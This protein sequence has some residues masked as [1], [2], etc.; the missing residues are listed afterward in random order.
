MGNLTSLQWG[1]RWF[2]KRR[3]VEK[4]GNGI[5]PLEYWCSKASVKALSFGG[6]GRG[7]SLKFSPK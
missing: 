5:T 2:L 1:N 3:M 4:N 7:H 6:H